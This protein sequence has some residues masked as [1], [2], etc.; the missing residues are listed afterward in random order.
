MFPLTFLP[1]G[2]LINLYSK[3]YNHSMFYTSY[4][5]FAYSKIQLVFRS[6]Y[7]TKFRWFKWYVPFFTYQF[8]FLEA[9]LCKFIVEISRYNVCFARIY[10]YSFFF[11]FLSTW[12]Y[13]ILNLALVIS[14]KSFQ[15][16][17]SFRV[18]FYFFCVCMLFYFLMA[19][20]CSILWMYC[21]LCNQFPINGHNNYE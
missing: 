3:I 10:M 16:P 13:T 7:G 17:T 15:I 4:S 5:F 20:Q 1:F 12:Q 6:A 9:S 2:R 14:W 21:N 19:I 18:L 8:L 11:F